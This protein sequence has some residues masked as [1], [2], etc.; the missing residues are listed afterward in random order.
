MILFIYVNLHFG[1]LDLRLTQMKCHLK[2]ND[3]HCLAPHIIF[4]KPKNVV[5]NSSFCLK[6]YLLFFIS[7]GSLCL[8]GIFVLQTCQIEAC[9]KIFSK[10]PHL[11]Q[12]SASISNI[13]KLRKRGENYLL[14]FKNEI[15]N[16]LIN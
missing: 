6:F 1:L 2:G 12:T 3:A 13:K 5:P 9:H 14:P 7:V 8:S 15:K 16:I 4:Y 11:H 10:T